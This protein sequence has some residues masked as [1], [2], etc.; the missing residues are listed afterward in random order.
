MFG[1]GDSNLRQ[2]KMYRLVKAKLKSSI[3]ELRSVAF[4]QACTRSF[5]HFDRVILVG[6]NTQFACDCQRFLDDIS[7]AEIGVL[8]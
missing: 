8:Q 1:E 5:K 6:V 2:E 3:V 4:N 7:G